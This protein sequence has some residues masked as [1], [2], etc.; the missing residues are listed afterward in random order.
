MANDFKTLIECSAAAPQLNNPDWCFC[1]CR[2]SLA[3][4][5]AGK[6]AYAESHITGAVYMDLNRDL[7]GPIIPGKTGRHPMPE[8][9]ALAKVFSAAGIDS[10]VQVVAYD[11]AGGPFAARLWWLLRWLGHDK[12]AVLNGGWQEWTKAGLP[13]SS[14]ST[15]R[16]ARSFQASPRPALV[17]N[18]AE[19][20]SAVS[21]RGSVLMDARGADRFRGEN[22]TIDPIGGH[23]PTAVSS[24]FTENLGPDGKLK[25]VTALK[26]KFA[27]AIGSADG[28]KVIN[29]C[30]SGVTAAHNILAM[31][32]A[33]LGEP[34][35]Y[36]G[37]WS[38]WITDKQRPIA[39][40]P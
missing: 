2:F 33:G 7:S 39:T 40:G 25:D 9:D 32:H 3:D 27:K 23:I 31:V 30:G 18:A 26:E 5:E 17:A 34:R 10:K 11:A 35:L 19:V 21:N 14:Q 6:R 24:P 37:S 15:P 13:V 36:P 20:L 28:T 38:E 22:E 4:A 12:V 16:R 1:D 29:Y 8:I